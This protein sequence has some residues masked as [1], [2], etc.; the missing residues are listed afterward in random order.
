MEQNILEVQVAAVILL[1]AQDRVLMQHRDGG[2]LRWPHKWGLPGGAIEPG[3]TP[4][5]GARRELEEETGLR[6]EGELPLFWKAVLPTIYQAGAS[7]WWHIYF[8]RTQARQE[9]VVLGEGQ[10]MVF[11]P[12]EKVLELDLTPTNRQIIEH[13][14]STREV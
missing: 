3:E 7:R 9:D 14:L 10:A 12:L 6:V 5:E 11:T 8:A 13:F 2:A 1:D 4:E